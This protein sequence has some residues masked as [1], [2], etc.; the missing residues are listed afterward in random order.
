MS[1]RKKRYPE[2]EFEAEIVSLSHE[3]RGVAKIDGKTTFIQFGL[4]GEKVK[5]KYTY[6]RAKFD[7]GIVTEILVPSKDRIE[8]VCEAYEQCGGCSLQHISAEGQLSHK[9]STLKE[10]FAHFGN[11]SPQ[12]WLAPLQSPKTEGYRSKARLG[13]RYVPKKDNRV[14]VGFRERNGRFL[15]DIKACEV[16]DPSVGK[17]LESLQTFIRSLDAHETIP[18]IEAAVDESKTALIIRHLEPLSETDLVKI[19]NYAEEKSFWIYLQSKGPNTVTLFYPEL[20]KEERFLSYS[21][22]EFDITIRYHPNDFTQVNTDLN[23]KML[24]QAITLLE[25]TQDD[26]ILDLFCGLG[27]FTLPMARK[28]KQVTGVEGEET[29]V[30]HAFESAAFNSIS[31]VNF[32]AANLFE[33]FAHLE[34]AQQSYT[35][36][37]LDPPRAGAE[38]ICQQMDKLNPEKIVYVSCNPATLARDA[39]ILVNEKGYTMTHAGIMDMFP[40]TTHVESMAVFIKNG[41]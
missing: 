34:W 30:K 7:E 21:I 27:N 4:P 36:V 19:K 3:G 41:K 22:P 29:M 18:Q 39:G 23:K 40:H 8:P 9:L 6:S 25:P 24:A 28:V 31:N 2:G 1:R 11:V 5:F 33:E 12:E 20:S 37:L 15:A 16:L 32:F 14:L 26:H 17:S 13:V 38:M 10:Q 35:K